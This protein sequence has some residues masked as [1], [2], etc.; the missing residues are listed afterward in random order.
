MDTLRK[1]LLE[2]AEVAEEYL[3]LSQEFTLSKI[4]LTLIAK[5]KLGK[6]DLCT[7]NHLDITDFCA[8][9]N[10]DINELCDYISGRKSPTLQL[11]M[12]LC[13]KYG[14]KFMFSI[15]KEE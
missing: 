15:L 14:Y 8:E 4:L 2:D 6:I 1:K 3:K 13:E 7:E 10:L 9:N 12:D 5:S 11:M